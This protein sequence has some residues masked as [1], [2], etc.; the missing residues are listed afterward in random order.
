MCIPLGIFLTIF[1]NLINIFI[2][3]N[4]RILRTHSLFIFVF[5]I[6][7]LDFF[8]GFS[9]IPRWLQTSQLTSPEVAYSHL[10]TCLVKIADVSGGLASAVAV[11][12]YVIVSMGYI[13]NTHLSHSMTYFVAFLVFIVA[14]VL[15]LPQ[16][17]DFD[18]TQLTDL[19][20]E[21]DRKFWTIDK[22]AF[23]DSSM[24][25]SLY[26]WIHAT[27]LVLLPFSL[28]LV[29]CFLLPLRVGP[30][31]VFCA[32]SC[33]EVS[34]KDQHRLRQLGKSLFIILTCTLCIST[35]T[36]LPYIDELLSAEKILPRWMTEDADVREFLSD[37]ARM[38]RAMVP[39]FVYFLCY[40]DYHQII[41]RK[42]CCTADDHYEPCASLKLL[43]CRR[44]PIYCDVL[45]HV[46]ARDNSRLQMKLVR[47]EKRN[48]VFATKKVQT[49]Q[50]LSR[51]V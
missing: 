3:G 43:C 47:R 50:E 30:R 17:F 15:V 25:S 9:L 31:H 45:D 26:Y 5:L 36:I 7:I 23:G 35:L 28:L 27:V 13:A 12:F 37:I 39:A 8:L 22:S 2:F 40:G 24:Y 44:E 20:V 18:V 19:C 41:R 4:P 16:W 48:G 32:C 34:T 6:A 49:A 14:S 42:I 1:L 51:W 33:L 21:S 46:R 38:T 11:W 10:L 29:T